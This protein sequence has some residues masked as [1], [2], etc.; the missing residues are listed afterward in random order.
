M[1]DT[2]ASADIQQLRQKAIESL[3]LA[4]ELFNR[5]HD[6]ARAE[7]VVILLHHSFELL[8]K[9]LI[10]E[11]TGTAYD[12]SRGFSYTFDT[13]L[14]KAVEDLKVLS[15]DHRKFLSILDNIRDSTVH[16][17]Q[18]ISETI[19]Y[20]LAQASVSLFSR[21]IQESTGK[22]LLD[23][24]PNRVL[25]IS[26][27]P[28]QQLGRV[29]DEELQKLSELL[30]TPG[31]D[32][33]QAMA[34]LRPLMAFKIGGEEQH[35][36]MTNEDLEVAVENLSSA[37][38]WRTV[39]PEIAKIKFESEGDSIAVGFKVVKESIDALPVVILKPEEA[40]QARGA[41]ITREVDIFD[42][43][44]MGLV[45]LAKNLGI[46]TPRAR[47]MIREYSIEADR[48]LFRVV[49]VGTQKLKRYSKKALDLL[50][51][52]AA[53]AEACWQKHRSDLS[54]RKKRKQ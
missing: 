3:T 13:C 22:Q 25:P 29:L 49:Q 15:D 23:L 12:E 41:I 45:Q 8:L 4:I 19:L 53:T 47:A 34:L 11:R 9:S 2:P 20:I 37:E 48:E 21:L 6:C 27:I 33:R 43:F 40:S 17:Y 28:P 31:T 42:K 14:R 5:P 39:F 16:Y 24:L 44:N 30:H 10:V 54:S 50:R 1:M 46:T 36:R 18:Q 52:K 38:N 51:E 35:R 26:A 7:A 32:K